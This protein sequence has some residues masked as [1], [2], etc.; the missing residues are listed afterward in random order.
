MT[1]RFNSTQLSEAI[2][3]A[4]RDTQQ[5]GEALRT[6]M[7][8]AMAQE[9]DDTILKGFSKKAFKWQEDARMLLQQASGLAQST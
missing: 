3:D 5:K 8:T 2:I 1:C 4:L 9:A 7:M 6:D